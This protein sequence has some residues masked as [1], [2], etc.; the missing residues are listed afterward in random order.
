MMAVVV[1]YMCYCAANGADSNDALWLENAQM[2]TPKNM[3]AF[4]Q[5]ICI[6]L[7]K[8]FCAFMRFIGLPF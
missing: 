8:I 6:W 2:A 3:N 5:Q 4:G 1:R 7:A